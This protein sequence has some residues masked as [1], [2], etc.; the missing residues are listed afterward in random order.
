M[1]YYAVN[2]ARHYDIE[3]SI[4]DVRSEVP[5]KSP[6]DIE[7][8]AENRHDLFFRAG[9]GSRPVRYPFD[10]L[11]DAHNR[12]INHLRVLVVHLDDTSNADEVLPWRLG[13][14]EFRSNRY[15]LGE[16]REMFALLGQLDW[17]RD[18]WQR[19]F[20]PMAT[21]AAG[22]RHWFDWA[23][24]KLSNGDDGESPKLPAPQQEWSA[25]MTRTEMARRIT[26]KKKPRPREV[27]EF[28]NRHGLEQVSG[29]KFRV[30]LDNMD[31]ATR[32]KLEAPLQE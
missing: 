7:I 12:F 28:L 23:E 32:R 10:A 11:T 4:A 2:I 3:I 17:E 6:R 1:A 15:V 19:A 21:H 16:L 14:L 9:E 8:L 29:R 31:A 18:A 24:S 22:W 20:A 26:G 13:S 27:D 5:N 30:R 25:P